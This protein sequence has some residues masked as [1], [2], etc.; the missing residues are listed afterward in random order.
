MQ[1]LHLYFDSLKIFCLYNYITYNFCILET[2]PVG[3]YA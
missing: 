3:K 1:L 2:A